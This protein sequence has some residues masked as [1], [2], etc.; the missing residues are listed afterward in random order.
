MVIWSRAGALYQCH[1]VSCIPCPHFLPSVSCKVQG[2][3][4]EIYLCE[5]LK[6]AKWEKKNSRGW[7]TDRYKWA[8]AAFQVIYTSSQESSLREYTSSDMCYL[9]PSAKLLQVILSGALGDLNPS[10]CSLNSNGRCLWKGLASPHLAGLMEFRWQKLTTYGKPIRECIRNDLLSPVSVLYF[11]IL[12]I[13]CTQ[14]LDSLDGLGCLLMSE[15]GKT[16]TSLSGV[17]A[18]TVCINCVRNV[19]WRH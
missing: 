2:V 18:N 13:T 10:L 4:V 15:F 16:Q 1:C 9:W 19:F 3:T 14:A 6:L 17:E 5:S 8:A 7:E 12:D 11:I